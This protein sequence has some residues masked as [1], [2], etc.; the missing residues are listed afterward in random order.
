MT[1][2]SAAETLGFQTEAKKLLQLMINSLYSNREI[3]LRELISNASDAIDKLRFEALADDALLAGDPEFRIR[4]EFD[5]DAK[6]LSVSDNGVGMTR[7]EV[8]ANLGTIAKSGTAEFLDRLTGDQKGDAT[9]IGQFGVGFYSAFIVAGEVEVLT[10]RAGQEAGVR[11]SSQGEESFTVE[12]APGLARGTKVTLALKDDAE[13][14]A[15]GFRLRSIVRQYSDHIGVPVE[16]PKEG[17]D[18]EGDPEFESV[19]SAKA[20]WTRSRSEI[21]DD[22]YREFY[23]HVSHDFEDPLVWSHNRVEGK[24]EYTSLLYVP[25]RAPYD[26]W[27]REAPRG[28]KLYVQR[29]FIMDEADEFLP[30][31]LRFVRGVVDCSDLP[32]NISREIL[33]KDERTRTIRNALTRRVLDTLGKL[34]AEQYG[35]FW[36]EF[37]QVLKEGVAEDFANKEALLKLL[38]FTSTH[39]EEAKQRISLA[40]YVGRMGEGQDRIYYL[41][42]ESDSAARQSPHLEVFRVRGIEVL[43]L[44]D[45]IDEWFM[46]FAGEFDGKEFQDVTRGELDLDPAEEA[47]EKNDAEESKEEEDD[48]LVSRIKAALGERVNEVRR[49]KRLTDSPACLVLGEHDM[50]LQMRRIME[51]AGQSAPDSK[52]DFEINAD[53]PLILRLDAEPD[54]DRFG[55]LVSV[56]FDQAALAEGNG[57]EQPGAY[58]RRINDLLVEL[59]G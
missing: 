5:K 3:F 38:R 10:R 54:E 21:E 39:D 12:D 19:N 48:S 22:E 1:D 4:I 29:V 17:D 34:E 20:L 53:H 55:D 49:S 40:D 23:R 37:G 44:T 45:R 52:P 28:V 25:G 9:L 30:L 24:L 36:D 15:D 46:S 8:V 58:V 47:A 2:A 18:E 42:A 6:T 27:N 33:Q 43:L 50:G 41:I 16:M 51:A 59:L 31:Y 57:I 32:L 35:E 56:L 13:E 26:L 7:E 11:W 14:F